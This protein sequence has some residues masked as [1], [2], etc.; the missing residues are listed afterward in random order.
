[1]FN[2]DPFGTYSDAEIWTALE[3][4]HMKGRISVLNDGLSHLLTEGGEN[5]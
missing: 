1:R 5:L 3:L 2:I 4:V